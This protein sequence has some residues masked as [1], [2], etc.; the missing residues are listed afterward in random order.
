MSPPD[1]I[2]LLTNLSHVKAFPAS[3]F[4]PPP[5]TSDRWIYPD[6][7]A[8]EGPRM[9]TD[10]H[11]DANGRY[12]R[13]ASVRFSRDGRERSLSRS[14]SSSHSVPP[15]PGPGQYFQPDFVS[16][17]WRTPPRCT[18]G[19]GRR[20]EGLL[21]MTHP[22]PPDQSPGPA[23]NPGRVSTLVGVPTPKLSPCPGRPSSASA[24][25]YSTPRS[26]S[27][28][29]LALDA[30]TPDKVARRRSYSIGRWKDREVVTQDVDM[31]AASTQFGQ[32]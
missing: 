1:N 20:V 32:Y 30:T 18:F 19:S 22:V 13:Q 7:T 28:G 12:R 2:L 27:A 15:E 3:K 5:R 26:A 17:P 23:Y 14:R 25:G 9:I 29:T 11:R 8:A 16:R 4:G 31:M 24:R 21:G 10:P 6:A